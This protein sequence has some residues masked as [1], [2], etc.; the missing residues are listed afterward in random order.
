ME[1]IIRLKSSELDSI[2]IEKIKALFVDKDDVEITL[3]F[4]EKGV[5]DALN[6]TQEQYKG[7]IDR[8]IKNV[9]QGKNMISFTGDEF[10]KM[11]KMLED[12]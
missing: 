4:A 5:Y 2:F 11:A 8:S 6:R 9:E 3:S 7:K 12:K 10:E 1:T